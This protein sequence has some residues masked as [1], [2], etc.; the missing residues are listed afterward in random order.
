[1]HINPLATKIRKIS[2]SIV[3]FLFSLLCTVTYAEN[4]GRFSTKSLEAWEQA[5]DYSLAH[6]VIAFAVYGRTR[7]ATAQQNAEIIKAYLAEHN[8]TCKYYLGKEE[9]MGA[10]IALFIQGLA[11]GP[12]ALSKALPLIHQVMAHYKEEYRS[13]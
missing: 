4:Q 6:P 9:R 1:M 10:S 3:L 2:L 5:Q 12:K 11:Y 7:D 13:S 8:I